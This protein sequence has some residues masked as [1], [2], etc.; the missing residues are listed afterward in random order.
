MECVYRYDSPLGG[1]LITSE[2]D[3]L[4][5]LYFEGEKD[6]SSYEGRVS[7]AIE[8]AVKWLDIYF[9][10]RDPGEIPDVKMKGSPF[11]EEVWEILKEIPYGNT[12]TY[13]DIAKKIAEKRGIKKMSAQ[14][15]G[16]AVGKNPVSIMVPCHRVVGNKGK[17]T[18]YGGGIWRKKA[19][20]ELEE[21]GHSDIMRI[22][23]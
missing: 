23:E 8:N 14:A 3:S 19:L 2:K 10:G 21:R 9:E 11:E 12:V 16:Q 17:L 22:H 6:S 13:G 15:V 20:L 1:I 4:T 18:G 5:G 7:P